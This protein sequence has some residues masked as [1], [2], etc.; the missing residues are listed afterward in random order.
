MSLK[1]LIFIVTKLS[2]WYNETEQC[3]HKEALWQK[4]TNDLYELTNKEQ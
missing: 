4:N 3:M 2:T 1:K